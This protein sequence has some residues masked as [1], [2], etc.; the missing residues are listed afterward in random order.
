VTASLRPYVPAD[1]A[2]V[3]AV[4]VRTAAAGGD[5]RGLYSD[6]QVLRVPGGYLGGYVVATADTGRFVQRWAHRGTPGF[7]ERHPAPVPT[8]PGGPRYTEFYAH[9]GFEPLPGHTERAP[10]VGLRTGA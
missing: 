3:A 6:D 8:P 1:R 7:R 10:L 5:A 2:A 9:L 4:C